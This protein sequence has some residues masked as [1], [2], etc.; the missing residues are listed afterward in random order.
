MLENVL[1]SSGVS[2][3]YIAVLYA[4]IS[5]TITLRCQIKEK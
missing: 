3:T 5:N 4:R 2:I 1:S